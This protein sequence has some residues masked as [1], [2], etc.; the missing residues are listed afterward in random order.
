MRTLVRYLPVHEGDRTRY[1]GW[2]APA[3]YVLEANAQLIARRFP[4][5]AFSILTPDGAAHWDGAELRFSAG[6]ERDAM[7]DDAALQSWWRSHHAGLLRGSRVGT[8]IPEAEEL[9]EAPRPPDR[10]PLGPV[11]LSLHP[12]AALQEAMPKPRRLPA[13]PSISAGDP[14]GV[15]RGSRACPCRCSWASSPATRRT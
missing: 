11:V 1:L 5:L 13:L 3:H 2:Y 8:A 14:D 4:D 12:D 10:P 6:V 9:D 7:P 15:R